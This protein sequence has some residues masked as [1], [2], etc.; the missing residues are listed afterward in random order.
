MSETLD[1]LRRHRAGLDSAANELFLRHSATA[2]EIVRARLRRDN[3]L[4]A[5]ME[6]QD[7]LQEA[8]GKAHAGLDRLQLHEE[9]QFIDWL[10]RII[11]NTIRDVART[12]GRMKRDPSRASPL[13]GV[14]EQVAA[15]PSPSAVAMGVELAERYATALEGL[16]D[17][18]REAILLRQHAGCS[19]RHVADA[20][21]LVTEAQARAAVSR[22]LA[23]LA[24]RMDVAR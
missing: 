19:Y 22:A 4:R 5:A 12:Q 23:T 21:G 16:D 24:E 17:A 1:L 2:L 20:L 7:V 18:A 13:D 8:F 15:T 6:S 14:A 9:G 11:E 10:A 3:P